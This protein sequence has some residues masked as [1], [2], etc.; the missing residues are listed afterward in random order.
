[1]T[2]QSLIRPVSP[3]FPAA[4]RR[5]SNRQWARL[6]GPAAATIAIGSILL[7]TV[8]SRTFSWRTSAL[9]DLGTA[10]PTAWLFNGSLVLAGLLAL[11]YAW[12][13][14]TGAA[15]QLG[16]LRAGTF[17]VAILGMAGI[18]LFPAGRPAH[19]P[20]ALVFFVF[21]SLTLLVDGVARFRLKTGKVA[22]LAGLVSPS[23]WPIWGLWTAPGGGIAVPEFVAAVLFAGWIGLLSP[24]RPGYLD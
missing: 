22:L 7:A 6:T 3:W 20:L 23:I 1:M 10:G 9:S 12:A 18:G 15:D 19:L 14:W 5:R 11:P 17:L 21:A 2:R 16:H 13:L 24:E 8:L 4:V